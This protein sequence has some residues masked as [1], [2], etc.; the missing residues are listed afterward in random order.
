M[1]VD[2]LEHPPPDRLTSFA[3]GKL[4]PA[5]IDAVERHLSNCDSCCQTLPQIEADTF[6]QLVQ[7]CRKPDSAQA[8]LMG[9]RKSPRSGF[10]KAPDLP[11]E[12]A[13]HSRY[14]VQDVLGS[15]GMGAVYKAE[16][17]L[18]HRLVA[19][20]VINPGLVASQAAVERFER[21][22]RAAARLH[23]PHVVAAYDAEQAGDLH[24][25]V[26]EYVDGSDLHKLLEQRGPLPAA[27]ACEYIRQAALGLQHAMD[28]GMVHRDLKPQNLM[29]TS[30]GQVKVLDFGLASVAS[31]AIASGHAASSLSAPVQGSGLTKTGSVMG[32]P[33]FMA[34]EQA[35]DAHA[36]D[37]RADIYSLGCTLYCLLSGK[38]PFPGGT[39]ADKILR[40]SEKNPES[41][42]GLRKDLPGALVEAVAKMM[43]KDP[44][45][46]YRTPAEVAHTLVPFTNASSG[47]G[48]EVRKDKARSRRRRLMG[49]LAAAAL[50]VVAGII[51]VATDSSWLVV[52]SKANNGRPE[53]RPQDPVTET[54]WVQ[55]FN[56]KDHKGWMMHPSKPGNWRFEEGIMIGAVRPSYLFSERG[57]FRDFH[58]R[59]V[60]KINKGGNSGILFHCTFGHL[61][62]LPFE[63]KGTR[64]P[65]GYEVELASESCLGA[66]PPGSVFKYNPKS[67]F[68]KANAIPIDD[69][70][71]LTLEILVRGNR[72]VT[73]V[74]DQTA[75]DF[76]DP[77]N[78]YPTGHFALQVFTPGTVVQF[79]KIE[80]K[81][82]PPTSG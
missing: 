75:T 20:K 23:H 44:A 41:L 81:E 64:T 33:D 80:I 5:E 51:Y 14:H 34:P 68:Y 58:L 26:M 36:A 54:G 76:E 21:E 2:L 79:K 66:Q 10:R 30:A 15:G 27:E 62:E 37:I 31:E 32:T 67:A 70:T 78:P 35:R 12:L 16:H 61:Y 56:G 19:L 13:Q 1:Q 71:W 53:R 73:K 74:N 47:P 50:L 42:S 82:L 55:L 4:D 69:E 65:L 17:R 60:L 18:M 29:V 57:D 8:G 48:S 45:A 49:T 3:L 11:A 40:H 72:I 43:A 28:N 59:A 63:P 7:D 38:V 39:T 22:V 46:R 6:L 77:L 25:L 9:S 52:G 24:F